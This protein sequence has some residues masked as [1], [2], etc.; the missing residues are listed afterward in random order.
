MRRETGAQGGLMMGW[1]EP[2]R[3]PGHPFYDRL[4]KLMLDGGFDA[5]VEDVRKPYAISSP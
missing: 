2:P 5:F 1:A 4:K 3:S